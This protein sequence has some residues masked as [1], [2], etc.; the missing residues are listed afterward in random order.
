M[1]GTYKNDDKDPKS[2]SGDAQSPTIIDNAVS[3]G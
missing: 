3:N 1:A 2:T